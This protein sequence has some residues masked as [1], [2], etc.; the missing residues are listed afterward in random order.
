[1]VA[2]NPLSSSMELKWKCENCNSVI[3]QLKMLD[4]I[5]TAKIRLQGCINQTTL[6]ESLESVRGV[7][8]TLL[9]ENH[10]LVLQ[11]EME[12]C[13]RI[14]SVIG[15]YEIKNFKSDV[16][17]ILENLMEISQ[18]LL[19]VADLLRPGYNRTRGICK[20]YEI[21]M[22]VFF[23]SMNVDF[24]IVFYSNISRTS[25]VLST[26]WTFGINFK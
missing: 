4:V 26:I 2:I 1:M 3:S 20:L 19:S 18:H 22:G 9:H 12:I 5:Q 15:F 6:E 8:N 21:V 14:L 7:T 16:S 25:A 17:S 10:F 24:Q 11:T 23:S 13:R